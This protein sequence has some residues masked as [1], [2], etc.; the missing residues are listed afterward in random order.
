M[1]IKTIHLFTK[2]VSGRGP[3]YD[4]KNI[5][6]MYF[7]FCRQEEKPYDRKMYKNYNYTLLLDFY[8]FFFF[9]LTILANAFRVQ[10]VID[11]RHPVD[12]VTIGRAV[13]ARPKRFRSA[14]AAAA[15]YPQN[16][17]KKKKDK[18]NFVRK[19]TVVITVFL[20]NFNFLALTPSPGS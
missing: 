12:D 11:V 16:I 2:T 4:N 15:N 8:R 1:K 20:F 19:R 7:F 17:Y 10:R 18:T 6:L 5:S 3:D 13:H 9:F 14:A